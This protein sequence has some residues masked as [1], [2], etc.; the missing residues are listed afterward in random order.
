[1][2]VEPHNGID[3]SWF[4]TSPLSHNLS[5]NMLEFIKRIRKF[6]RNSVAIMAAGCL[7]FEWAN[8]PKDTPLNKILRAYAL[9]VATIGLGKCAPIGRQPI[10][11]ASFRILTGELFNLPTFKPDDPAYVQSEMGPMKDALQDFSSHRSAL[12]KIDPKRDSHFLF[13]LL[14]LSRVALVQWDGFSYQ[15]NDFMRQL[16]IYKKFK[17]IAASPPFNASQKLAASEALFLGTTVERFIR[18]IWLI[19]TFIATSISKTKPFPPAFEARANYLNTEAAQT[20]DLTDSDLE[21]VAN[22]LSIPVSKYR[23]IL[24]DIEKE[25]ISLH[26]KPLWTMYDFPLVHFDDLEPSNQ[27]FAVSPW[28]LMRRSITVI[29]E[30]LIDYFHQNKILNAFQLRGIAY[31]NYLLDVLAPFGVKKVDDMMSTN[32]SGKKCD[33]IWED[34]ETVVFIE[35][36]AKLRPNN[37][38]TF[39]NSRSLISSWDSACEAIQQAADVFSEM[40]TTKKA[41]L[42][43]AT[44]ENIAEQVTQF[45]RA[46]KYW[47]FLQE[48]NLDAVAICV[49]SHIEHAIRKS[50]PTE[51]YNAVV[52]IWKKLDPLNIQAEIYNYDFF[53]PNLKSE[54]SQDHLIDAWDSIIPGYKKA[55]KDRR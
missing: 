7:W 39:I 22:R 8:E 28:R 40:K 54:D 41:I 27:Y 31:E 11:E 19:H 30:E 50:T 44:D 34:S 17:E 5:S 51:T 35:A 21:M 36:K 20:L 33:F 4:K 13:T 55:R 6:D 2:P 45:S 9:F 29:S 38:A 3:I 16:L 26:L 37:D 49:T 25:N 46:A 42:L 1:M 32:Y 47:D 23:E 48:T 12:S 52:S 18:S 10:D 53:Q 14:V 15:M 24:N 43:I